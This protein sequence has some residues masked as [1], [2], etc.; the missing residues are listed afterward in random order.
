[1]TKVITFHTCGK[2]YSS[3]ELNDS[4]LSSSSSSP[5]GGSLSTGFG[6]RGLFGFGGKSFFWVPA[7]FSASQV[8][9][10][11]ATVAS[12][13]ALITFHSS[14]A[15]AFATFLASLRADLRLFASTSTSFSLSW[16]ASAQ[17]SS[18]SVRCLPRPLS[19]RVV[20]FSFFLPFF[21]ASICLNM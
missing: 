7:A 6:F 12:W 17:M 16:S 8:N 20:H 2:C 15:A 18:G 9:C 1:V 3:S 5:S 13:A 10:H 11:S 14:S 21:M 4:E 19:K